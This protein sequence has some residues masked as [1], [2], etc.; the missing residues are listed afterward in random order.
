MEADRGRS[1]VTPVRSFDAPA[2]PF[3]APLTLVVVHPPTG[4]VKLVAV[5]L[6]PETPRNPG[7]V[8]LGKE[9]SPL[10]SDPILAFRRRKAP[11]MKKS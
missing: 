4:R 7:E 5:I 6:E 10:V 2:G 8:H 11:R 9:T 3:D 1:G